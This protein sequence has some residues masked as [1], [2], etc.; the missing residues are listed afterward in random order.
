MGSMVRVA[1]IR[2]RINHGTPG[3]GA[4]HSRLCCDITSPSDSQ[5]TLYG[6]TCSEDRAAVIRARIGNGPPGVGAGSQPPVDATRLDVAASQFIED[7]EDKTEV[8]DRCL[9]P[10]RI[11]C[12][13]PCIT[14][15]RFY[16]HEM[17]K[18][19]ASEFIGDM[20]ARWQPATG[21][22][23]YDEDGRC[24]KVMDALRLRGLWWCEPK[25]G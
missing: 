7:M 9:P 15:P 21:N 11:P 17:R 19:A 25:T 24:C 6:G 5:V 4:A 23:T 10:L 1:I 18:D 14:L 8:P 20:D 2:G 12:N 22:R 3:V 13:L 16:A